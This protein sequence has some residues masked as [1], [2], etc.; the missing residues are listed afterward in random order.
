M[1][2]PIRYTRLADGATVAYWTLGS[3]PPLLHMPDMPIALDKQWQIPELASWYTALA[4]QH[5]VVTWDPPG[6]GLSSRDVEDVSFTTAQVALDA[7]AEALALDKFHLFSGYRRTP[8]AISF[9]ANN[10]GRVDRLVLWCPYAQAVAMQSTAGHSAVRHL[11]ET[12]WKTYTEYVLRISTGLPAGRV[13]EVAA[14]ARDSIS[15]DV[16]ARQ[17]QQA[18]GTDTSSLLSSI[19]APTLVLHRRDVSF[20]T[21]EFSRE[22]AASIPNAS[23]AVLDGESIYPH[24]GD[25]DTVLD[26]VLEF[27]ADGSRPAVRPA[28]LPETGILA[29][30]CTDLENSTAMMDHLG[31]EPGRA[32]L[33]EHERITRQCLDEYSGHEFKTAG[34]S[35][36][37]WFTSAQRA[38]ACAV[39]L[40][41]RIREA[42]MPEGVRL[43]VGIDAGEPIPEDNDFFGRTVIVAS[44]V[45][46]QADGGQVL[47]S[48]VVRQLASGKGFA[49]DDRGERTLKGF[50]EPTR[51]WMVGWQET[52]AP[53]PEREMGSSTAG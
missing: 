15:R 3:G 50:S 19:A 2:P 42:G 38:V 36:L 4:N 30:L 28:N 1:P 26:A 29:V 41:R 45:C 24:F 6:V 52:S 31:D 44:R 16:Y 32:F 47:V 20:L 11:F 27:L 9:A 34:D 35:F 46:G 51:I 10:P 5:T 8:S 17:S 18:L 39:A 37:A 23:L 48:D 49:F 40:Q 13:T 21:L 14:L 43:R 25:Q 53:P 33:R 7:V 12:D 22:I